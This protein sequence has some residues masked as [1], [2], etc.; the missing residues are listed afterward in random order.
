MTPQP[1]I[2]CASDFSENAALA[3]RY[4]IWIAARLDGRIVVVSVVE[5]LLAEAARIEGFTSVRKD[6]ERALEQ[7]IE[8]H[9]PTF[10]STGRVDSRVLEGKPP[11]EIQRCAQAEQADLVV[12][13]T[14]GLSGYRRLI[15]G[16][17]ARK[18]LRQTDRPVLVVPSSAASQQSEIGAWLDGSIFAPVDLQRLVMADVSMAAAVAE[19]LKLPLVLLYV[20]P[21]LMAIPG[22]TQVFAKQHGAALELARADLE[23]V[24]VPLESPSLR[25]ESIAVSGVPAEEIA[26]IAEERNARLIVMGLGGEVDDAP[27][28][29]AYRVLSGASAAVLALP[30]AGDAESE[31]RKRRL[32]NLMTGDIRAK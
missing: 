32:T 9:A 18:V 13:G 10:A 25:V 30:D 19:A 22:L 6:T 31:D 3:F 4:A 29:V 20:A 24:A 16:S 7:W 1:V 5:P 12:I 26:R 27:G 11:Q 8:T 21:P 17:I 14:Q 2:V 23:R 15:L 28:S